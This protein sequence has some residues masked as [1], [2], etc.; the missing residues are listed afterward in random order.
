MPPPGV[1]GIGS[2]P[3]GASVAY[4]YEVRAESMFRSQLFKHQATL[5]LFQKYDVRQLQ[6]DAAFYLPASLHDLENYYPT[7]LG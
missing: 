3:T 5:C 4:S 1:N 6:K 2:R 7:R